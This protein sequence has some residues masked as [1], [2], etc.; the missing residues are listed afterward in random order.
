M[1]RIHPIVDNQLFRMAN[2][3]L[4]DCATYIKTQQPKDPAYLFCKDN[5][6]RQSKL[7]QKRFP[8]LVSYAVKANPQTQILNSLIESGVEAFDVASIEEI[9]LVYALAPCA[10]LHFNNPVKSLEAIQEAYNRYGV[11]SF[12]IDDAEELRKIRS[13]VG[14]HRDIEIS[15][16]FKIEG[17][18]AAYDF[19]SKFGVY[20]KNA[21]TLLSAVDKCGY[22]PSLTFHPGSQC[23][24]AQQYAQHI[25]AAGWIQRTSSVQLYRLNVGG[26]FPTAYTDSKA[27][28]LDV[29]FNAI[30]E[31]FNRHFSHTETTLLCEPGRSMVANS[32]TLLTRVIHRREDDTLFLN[33]GIYGGLMEQM[34][35]RLQLPV[36]VWRDGKRLLGVEKKFTVFGPT[37]DALDKLPEIRLPI[38]IKTDDYIE[39]GFLGAYGSSTAT[40]FNGFRSEKYIEVDHLTRF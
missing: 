16:R 5:L 23:E 30:A 22:R 18:S 40:V 4:P 11:R 20:K 32:C 39:F 7:F 15:V 13:I 29:Y 10:T 2:N 9:R 28:D 31:S 12:V 37:C 17:N 27:P 8:G 34:I 26:G 38:D 24:D 1:T 25:D 36:A 6:I 19:T 33:D 14:K 35:V 3:L 21:A